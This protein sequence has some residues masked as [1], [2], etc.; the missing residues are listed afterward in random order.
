MS[1]LKHHLDEQ[2]LRVFIDALTH[3]FQHLTQEFADVLPSYLSLHEIPIQEYTGLIAISG[4]YQGQV[5]FSAPSA[6]LR[7]LLLAQGETVLTESNLLDQVGEIANTLAG[8]ARSYFGERFTIS[9]PRAQRGEPETAIAS[10]P[11]VIPLSWKKY[12]ALLVVDIR[13]AQ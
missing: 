10:R 1:A 12:K 13:T 7:H 9:T 6:L 11:Y 8:N 3:Y 5:Y 4:Q 2:D